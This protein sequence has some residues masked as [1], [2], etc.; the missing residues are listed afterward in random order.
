ME[1]KSVATSE[2]ISFNE[3]ESDSG[4][5]V[6]LPDGDWLWNVLSADWAALMSL[7]ESAESTVEMKVPI[8]SVPGVD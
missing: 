7:L 2:P 8:G 5:M 6:P 4:D 1:L 3:E